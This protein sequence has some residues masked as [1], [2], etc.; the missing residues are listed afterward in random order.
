QTYADPPECSLLPK[1]PESWY[2]NSNDENLPIEIEENKEI[3]KQK[4]QQK[5][6]QK[7]H[8]HKNNNHNKGIYSS[9]YSTR[10]YEKLPTQYISV[11][12]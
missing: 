1:P 6:Y 4:I 12:G 11:K 8:N 7:N 3:P 2:L 9:C 10:Y 5:S